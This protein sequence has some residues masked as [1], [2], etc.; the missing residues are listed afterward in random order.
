MTRSFIVATGLLS[1]AAPPAFSTGSFED[2]SARA[3][4][5]RAPHRRALD[6]SITRSDGTGQAASFFTLRATVPVRSAFLIRVEVPYITLA[7]G[8]IIRDGFGDVVLR[9]NARAWTGNRKTFQFTGACRFGS[10]T[11]ELFPYSTASID[12]E[13]GAAYIDSLGTVD[14]RGLSPLKSLSY[15]ISASYVYVMRLD[16]RLKETELHG[17]HAIAG[18]GL[19]T[20]L[21]RSLELEAGGLGLFFESGATREICFT[22]VSWAVSAAAQV[23]A[24]AQVETG[25]SSERASDASVSVGLV[26]V[27]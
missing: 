9:A 23:Y 21:S 24:A 1:F 17:Q 22:R 14:E 25:E 6:G 11:S 3:A 15:W 10:G 18:G 16:D 20:A 2:A 7:A 13:V 12:T 5:L 19:L 26:V 27:F 8:D 4:W